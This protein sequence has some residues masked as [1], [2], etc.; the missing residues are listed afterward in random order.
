MMNKA[1]STQGLTKRYSEDV[2]AVDNVDFSISEN[3]VYALLGPN[4]AGK[5]TLISILS[6]LTTPTEGSAK[7]MEF[8]VVQQAKQVREQIG[9]TFQEIVLDPDLTGRESLDFH[10]NLYGINKAERIKRTRELLQLVELESAADRRIKTYSGGMKRRLELARGLITKPKVLF[11]DEPTQGLDP[12]N[13][14]NIW[15]YINLLK[16]NNEMTILLTTHYMEEAEVLADCVGIM[17]NGRIIT[18]G[19]P[20]DL[21]DQMGTDNIQIMGE[22]NRDEF[23]KELEKLPYVQNLNTTKN[24]IQ[25][26]VDSGNRRLVKIIETSIDCGYSIED[27]SV[28]KPSLGDVFLKFTGRQLRDK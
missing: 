19:A 23:S 12:Q 7:I 25:I 28:S 10:A 8:D 4:G 1:I 17:D 11:L 13:R 6:T 15:E 27:I 24:I 14:T 16:K 5:T 22:G 9:V 26:G 3:T 18:E 20:D 2:L 21:I